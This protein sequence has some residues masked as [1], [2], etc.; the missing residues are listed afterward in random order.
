[1]SFLL[2]GVQKAGTTALARWLA[3]H[4]RLCLPVGKEAH[5]FDAPD[6]NEAASAQWVDARYA[7]HHPE[8]H[9]DGVLY[10]DATPIYLFHPRLIARIA[11]YN[12][13]MRWLVLLRDPVERAISHWAMERG[14]GAER[15]PLWAAVLAEP[16]R[17]A[18]HRDDFADDSPL[19]THSYAARGDYARQLDCLFAH[20][21]RTQVLLIDNA[22]LRA[23]PAAC[24]HRVHAFLGVEV[25][26]PP[27]FAPV[28]AGDYRVPGRFALGRLLLRWRLLAARRRLRTTYGID[29][30][31]R[32]S[33]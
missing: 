2:G 20:F 11:R 28:F 4:P 14:R 27:D 22:E 24:L 1:M 15:L 10:G 6:F 32:P 33:S 9:D 3:A 19:R 23:E 29:W 31:Y 13:A 7:V 30:P 25:V 26:P 5:V 17:L 12:P 21:P 16:F 18:G 8:P